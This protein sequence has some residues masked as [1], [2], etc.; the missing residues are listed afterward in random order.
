MPANDGFRLDENQ[1]LLPPRPEPPQHHPEQFVRKSEPRLRILLFQD[2]KL[3]PKSQVFQ[4][5]VAAGAKESGKQD[6]Q[7]SQQ[8]QHEISLTCRQVNAN[9]RL[10]CLIQQQ[11]GIL[12]HHNLAQR[13]RG[14]MNR[15]T[16]LNDSHLSQVSHAEW[17]LFRRFRAFILDEVILH[18]LF[19]RDRQ[20]LLPRNHAVAKRHAQVHG[21]LA[22]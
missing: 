22:G 4:K 18:L 8:V 20:H 1:Y 17:N 2:G 7:K 13:R 9:C 10:F 21:S 11:I 15:R 19:P 6:R 5:Q 12:A 16:A 14:H 3:L